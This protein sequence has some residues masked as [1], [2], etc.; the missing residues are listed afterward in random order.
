MASSTDPLRA[1]LIRLLSWEEAHVG[2]D[3]AVAGVPAAERGARAAG[4]GAQAAGNRATPGE[5]DTGGIQNTARKRDNARSAGRRT[6]RCCYDDVTNRQSSL[7][8]YAK[9]R[10]ISR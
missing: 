1:Q 10:R 3:K 2:F 7:W 9:R 8:R 6:E 4:N 5:Q